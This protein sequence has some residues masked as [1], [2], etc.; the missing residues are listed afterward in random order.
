MTP[1]TTPT[2]MTAWLEQAWM[3]RYLDHQLASEE[4]NWFEAY[5]LDKPELLAM[6]EAD[7]RLRDALAAD[8]SMRHMERSVDRGGRQGGA[9]GD[10]PSGVSE[11]TPLAY[12]RD[13]AEV[14]AQAR[15]RFTANGRAPVWLAMAATLVLGLGV[16]F[17]GTRSLAPD[18]AAPE[19][20][21]SPTRIIYDTMRGEPTPPRV[22]H[23]DSKSPYVFIEVAVPPGAEN[24]TLKM[25]DAP[26]QKLTVSPDG[27]VSF[28]VE[29]EL[30]S[31]REHAKVNY[32]LRG[33]PEQHHVALEL[34]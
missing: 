23:A 33:D 16:G 25:G 17:V 27:F 29:R 10:A 14:R 2:R 4:A 9:T 22:E 34:Q 31:K 3:V 20:V 19:L 1:T 26:E 32:V 24:I 7:T 13:K 11:P 15:V 5:A 6:I 30:V 12:A 18:N 21:A 28:L 8:A